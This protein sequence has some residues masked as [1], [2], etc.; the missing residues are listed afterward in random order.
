MARESPDDDRE[1]DP[2]VRTFVE[3]AAGTIRRLE[4]ESANVTYI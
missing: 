3:I 1:A 4:S 2:E